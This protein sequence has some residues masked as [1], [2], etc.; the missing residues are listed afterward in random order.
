MRIEKSMV[1]SKLQNQDTQVHVTINFVAH[2][3]VMF[4]PDKYGGNNCRGQFLRLNYI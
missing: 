3:L 4:A 1:T 2:S